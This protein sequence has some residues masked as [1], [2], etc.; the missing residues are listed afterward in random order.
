MNRT[1]FTYSDTS[2][3]LTGRQL[4]FVLGNE[5]GNVVIVEDHTG[6]TVTLTDPIDCEA[7]DSFEVLSEHICEAVIMR[8]N[9]CYSVP[10]ECT[11]AVPLSAIQS[12]DM[13]STYNVLIRQNKQVTG[14][15][16]CNEACNNDGDCKKFVLDE[17][18]ICYYTTNPVGDDGNAPFDATN[19]EKYRYDQPNG[20]FFKA[21][22]YPNAVGVYSNKY[23]I[24]LEEKN[25]LSGATI[26]CRQR[27]ENKIWCTRYSVRKMGDD[28]IERGEYLSNQR[29]RH[30]KRHYFCQLFPHN[31]D[32]LE[33]YAPLY[34]KWYINSHGQLVDQKTSYPY[35]FWTRYNVEGTIGEPLLTMEAPTTVCKR[36]PIYQGPTNTNVHIS[37]LSAVYEGW[38]TLTWPH[39]QSV[40][41]IDNT[42][43][44]TLQSA[45]GNPYDL[46]EDLTGIMTLIGSDFTRFEAIALR[47]WARVKYILSGIEKDYLDI[48]SSEREECSP[49]TSDFYNGKHN[50]CSFYSWLDNVID[51]DDTIR[52]VMNIYIPSTSIDQWTAGERI[53]PFYGVPHPVTKI[54]DGIRD[55]L[56]TAT[57][58]SFNGTQK[59]LNTEKKIT[60][61][62]QCEKAARQYIAEDFSNKW[63]GF[64]FTHRTCYITAGDCTDDGDGDIK[65]K[66]IDDGSR[67]ITKTSTHEEQ[68]ILESDSISKCIMQCLRTR[69]C[70]N[71]RIAR[72][73]DGN[74]ECRMNNDKLGFDVRAHLRRL[75][76]PPN[77]T[78]TTLTTLSECK[79]R[80]ITEQKTY[81][82]PYEGMCYVSDTYHPEALETTVDDAAKFKR[83]LRACSAQTTC[84][85]FAEVD[86]Y[87]LADTCDEDVTEQECSR[88]L[89]TDYTT[90]RQSDAD[91]RRARGDYCDTQQLHYGG[92]W[93]PLYGFGDGPYALAD[94]VDPNDDSITHQK[95]CRLAEPAMG[96]ARK[97]FVISEGDKSIVDATEENCGS[98]S[99]PLYIKQN[100]VYTGI[101]GA[102][103]TCNATTVCPFGTCGNK[104]STMVCKNSTS[105]DIQG[106]SISGDK[107][108]SG[109]TD[110]DDGYTCQIKDSTKVCIVENW[111]DVNQTECQWIADEHSM[112]MV[113][114]TLGT[115]TLN[116]MVCKDTDGNA[117][118][119]MFVTSAPDRVPYPSPS[120][121]DC[122]GAHGAAEG[123]P[124]WHD[125]NETGDHQGYCLCDSDANC[126][127]G[128]TCEA[129]SS[130]V[131][132]KVCWGED[133]SVSA[134]E[135]GMEVINPE[136]HDD[137]KK[138]FN[139]FDTSSNALLKYLKG[140]VPAYEQRM[141][142]N[143]AR[144]GSF[145]ATDT[146]VI[147]WKKGNWRYGESGDSG[148][149]MNGVD[150]LC[151][152][153][154]NR[155]SSNGA[156]Q[157]SRGQSFYS[158]G[159]YFQHLIDNGVYTA[160]DIYSTFNYTITNTSADGYV[161]E[162]GQ[163]FAVY[164]GPE[165]TTVGGCHETSHMCLL[166]HDN[167]QGTGSDTVEPTSTPCPTNEDCIHYRPQSS[168]LCILTEKLQSGGF[169]RAMFWHKSETA[170]MNRTGSDG[171]IYYLRQIHTNICPPQSQ[172]CGCFHAPFPTCDKEKIPGASGRRLE[173]PPPLDMGPP[174]TSDADCDGEPCMEGF[175]PP[176]PPPEEGESEDSYSGGP[177]APAPAPAPGGTCQTQSCPEAG[178][179][180]IWGAGDPAWG[181][182]VDKATTTC[183][184]FRDFVEAIGSSTAVSTGAQAAVAQITLPADGFV[185]ATGTKKC[186][187]SPANDKLVWS[188][189]GFGEQCMY[190]VTKAANIPNLANIGTHQCKQITKT[191]TTTYI[192]SAVK[193]NIPGIVLSKES[194]PF[195]FFTGYDH[196]TY[197]S[198]RRFARDTVT[199]YAPAWADTIHG[200]PTPYFDS[201]K[202]EAAAT[203][204]NYC[205]RYVKSKYHP[206]WRCDGT[207]GD[208]GSTTAS[209][210][211]FC[212][213]RAGLK[214]TC[215]NKKCTD[216]DYDGSFSTVS[217]DTNSAKKIL[218]GS[219]NEICERTTFS[220]DPALYYTDHTVGWDLSRRG[221]C[222]RNGCGYRPTSQCDTVRGYCTKPLYVLACKMN[223]QL[224]TFVAHENITVRLEEMVDIGDKKANRYTITTPNE[225]V[226]VIEGVNAE[227]T[228]Q[229][230]PIEPT[231][232]YHSASNVTIHVRY[233]DNLEIFNGNY[234]PESMVFDSSVGEIPQADLGNSFNHRK[235][236]QLNAQ[237]T[238]FLYFSY[239]EN[240]D[241]S[242]HDHTY[243][244][245]AEDDAGSEL[246]CT[247]ID[248][249]PS[250]Y[251][252]TSGTC[253]RHIT[254]TKQATLS[255][256][257]R[258][259]DN[260]MFTPLA[261]RIDA[262]ELQPATGEKICKTGTTH[263]SLFNG[264]L[265]KP[266]VGNRDLTI[267]GEN[268]Y[269]VSYDALSETT[270]EA[271]IDNLYERTP[272]YGGY[273]DTSDNKLRSCAYEQNSAYNKFD[274]TCE[275]CP[276][277]T[278]SYPGGVQC[279]P[280]ASGT[281]RSAAMPDGC[282]RCSDGDQANEAQTEC[283]RCPAGKYSNG[284]EA[285]Q[286]CPVGLYSSP[287][288]SFCWKFCLDGSTP[289]D[290]TCPDTYV[291]TITIPT[292]PCGLGEDANKNG[293][294]DANEISGCMDDEACNYN[295]SATLSLPA[296][297]TYAEDNYYCDGSCINDQND[298]GICDE[299]EI[300][301]C[302]KPNACNPFNAN[303]PN[304]VLNNDYC[305]YADKHRD[306]EG[307]CLEGMV[308]TGGFCP[309]EVGCTDQRACNYNPDAIRADTCYYLTDKRM[310]SGGPS[311]RIC[312]E[313]NSTIPCGTCINDADEDG[314]CDEEEGCTNP[315][316]CNYNPLAANDTLN[317]AECVIPTTYEKCVGP[318]K[319]CKND[320][321]DNQVCDELE[322]CMDSTACNY[323]STATQNST[324]F[325]CKHKETGLTCQDTCE[326]DTNNDGICGDTAFDTAYTAF[327]DCAD[328]VN[329]ANAASMAVSCSAKQDF[330]KL[331]CCGQHTGLCSSD[332][333]T[334]V[335]TT[336]ATQTYTF[337]GVGDWDTVLPVDCVQEALSNSTYCSLDESGCPSSRKSVIYE[338][339]Q[340]ARNGGTCTPKLPENAPCLCSNFYRDCGKMEEW[341]TANCESV[342]SELCTTVYSSMKTSSCS[343]VAV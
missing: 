169:Y 189:S 280:C 214:S 209:K 14:A 233:S 315:A 194:T 104:D 4:R 84:Q 219:V 128:Y 122:I 101:G 341:Y 250:G 67:Y 117:V 321:D 304:H 93:I 85:Y 240:R 174:C 125:G 262:T 197:T 288:M 328:N 5:A 144:G 184:W 284:A 171:N 97:K 311:I 228:V 342:C 252:C 198:K 286:D 30:W 258:N 248:N 57:V 8:D 91:I 48:G 312:S 70:R 260:F 254:V 309:I 334:C 160:S 337:S 210:N 249:C 106:D 83:A 34:P 203:C 46:P 38:R 255:T 25:D 230:L 305:E 165:C 158:L 271:I 118:A 193:T 40:M 283:E 263:Y 65:F 44:D 319:K 156:Y 215:V 52:G 39:I 7:D 220:T 109:T 37:A 15:H 313:C 29:F 253:V 213:A 261:S 196:N 237:G 303:N 282:I 266:P 217:T 242:K 138:F 188:E 94:I 241:L 332:M 1:S 121:D 239:K 148:T 330:Y 157:T 24:E 32:F 9:K 89:P 17:N 244:D 295:V 42:K 19:T 298:N 221:E 112:D 55:I 238:K 339:T 236:I 285:C 212:R 141:V 69:D 227:N 120:P 316:A 20:L 183:D 231:Y 187:F 90:C 133:P 331:L 26:E 162:C 201:V 105:G 294:C 92:N 100:F 6:E 35:T 222:P 2:I 176:P 326:T 265:H 11:G 71:V 199:R 129:Y 159:H 172:F 270:K 119:N 180:F 268:V 95:G 269:E 229:N 182:A 60:T 164:H 45:F 21:E 264:G 245:V 51:I 68:V 329:C 274:N 307:N 31:G 322:G 23:I 41:G 12:E 267:N 302:D 27:C 102:E 145:E 140:Y 224:D 143:E 306:C 235:R 232:T 154:A 179:A 142:W 167:I 58:K 216:P 66:F 113:T 292:E 153:F 50:A 343:Y 272:V 131:L 147:T 296:T 200:T 170:P 22:S 152:A 49:E 324:Y 135:V 335:N 126:G 317:D 173:E 130:S 314:L 73:A 293:V 246:T 308:D 202:V 87:E 281:I 218:A 72:T 323:K 175:C 134:S 78:S 61:G 276:G 82:I 275:R 16:A 195:Q 151:P 256:T 146:D 181:G 251:T 98:T 333:P 56:K 277:G 191:E 336:C 207:M 115:T 205:S 247:S 64:S 36:R 108:C 137:V 325:T 136:C 166:D 77:E 80:A 114:T 107:T 3:D 149:L 211:N 99:L 234:D 76:S 226:T 204:E 75:V 150:N 81:Y 190:P 28:T 320:V 47:K 290:G 127:N 132:T 123:F 223:L 259:S 208:V 318:A 54:S 225:V 74:S 177:S 18:D 273:L 186:F 340:E 310:V 291:E 185:A 327:K 297:C 111:K 124:A 168:G 299:H 43:L 278:F 279:I 289:T 139:A 103:V 338:I 33:K 243:L 116:P 62:E 88:L 287:G 257:T 155:S 59:I 63:D 161:Y 163:K 300:H 10:E 110:C 192:E 13:Q 53:E 301:A 178:D 96:E 79:T 86:G 206:F